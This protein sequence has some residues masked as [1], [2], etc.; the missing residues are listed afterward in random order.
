MTLCAVLG[1]CHA[2]RYRLH[3]LDSRVWF[4]CDEAV[5][6]LGHMK[7][8]SALKA[9]A[10]VITPACLALRLAL[11]TY[12]LGLLYSH[13]LGAALACEAGVIQSV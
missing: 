10:G 4:A 3:Y 12:T 5:V 11:R 13:V 6:V 8:G 1:T 2:P 9:V 7:L